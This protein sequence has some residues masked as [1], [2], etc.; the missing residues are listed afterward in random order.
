MKIVRKIVIG[1]TGSVAA[2]KAAE[3]AR[4]LMDENFDVHVAMTAA[5][6]KFVAPLTFEALTGNAVLRAGFPEPGDD[7][8]GHINFTRG[9]ALVLVAPATA[10]FIGKMANGL[11]DDSLGAAILASEA[12]VMVAPAMN[13]NMYRHPAVV[14]NIATLAERGVDI[15]GPAR[16]RLACG[17]EG[18]GKMEDVE[19]IVAGTLAFLQ[20]AQDLTGA[21]LI[22]TAGGT[23]EPI[24]A[25]RYIGNRS[26]GKMGA[27][28]AEAAARRGADVTLVAA[29]MSAP[30]PGGVDVVRVTTAMEMQ[31]E[32]E[33]LFTGADALVMAAAVGDYHAISVAGAKVKK[34][35][36]WD[37]ALAP[38]PD[39][40]AGLGRRRAGQVV[41]GFAAETEN[42]EKEGREKL[43]RKN[44]DMIVV[45][46]VSRPDIGF[47]SDHNEVILISRDGDVEK[48]P[49]RPKG[50][51]AETILDNL[52]RMLKEKEK[53][54]T[55]GE[56]G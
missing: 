19:T 47:D 24:D 29:E 43:L 35:D 15:I 25:V 30:V 33:K 31:R 55:G 27:A 7:P 26:S 50:E 16:G 37:V 40:L 53:M 38:N 45:N 49:R 42:A 32:L 14:E 41:I 48:T 5:A 2:Y 20:R 12:P 13:V 46:D 4:R 11:A 28:I 10:S 23:K 51:I 34:K 18:E 3:L 44:L 36:R 17:D 8:M 22:V 1:V 52:S 54:K 9:A 39:I 56:A 21:R 6:E